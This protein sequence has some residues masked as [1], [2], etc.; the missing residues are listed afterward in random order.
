M[1]I[2]HG[3]VRLVIYR[4]Q[5]VRV[6]SFHSR[7]QMEVL[8]KGSHPRKRDSRG[9]LR[10]RR[11]TGGAGGCSPQLFQFTFVPVV[12]PSAQDVDGARAFL[13][14]RHRAQHTLEEK[15]L[16]CVSLI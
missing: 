1:T 2:L 5:G 9:A 4:C 8:D 6:K 16:G 3:L 10:D 14:W 12:Q 15:D 11:L 7:G 13:G